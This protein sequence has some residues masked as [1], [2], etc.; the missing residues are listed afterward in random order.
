MSGAQLLG[1]HHIVNFHP[2][3]LPG[4]E[5]VLHLLLS[6]A[7][8]HCQAAKSLRIYGDLYRFIP[9]LVA[10]QGF[11]VDEIE[12]KHHPR[13]YG[14]SRYGLERMPRG[15]FDLL[16][17]LFLTQ[18]A[19]RPLHLFGG[20][21]AGLGIAGFASLLYLSV[22]WFLGERPIGTR[23]LFMGGILLLLL[24]AQI[25]GLGLVGELITHSS[26]QAGDQYIVEEELNP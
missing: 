4:A 22:L 5:I 17:V 13:K 1:L 7:H 24:G 12:V 9:A 26:F 10:A 16:T 25:L 11:R 2:E 8:Y 19:R 20:I 18:Y 21:G 23:P 15:F 6:V 3:A 14:K